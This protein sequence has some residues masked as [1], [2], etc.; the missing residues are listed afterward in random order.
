ML[1]FVSF[2]K[3]PFVLVCR[4]LHSSTRVE[5]TSNTNYLQNNVSAF[6]EHLSTYMH[7]EKKKTE[8]NNIKAGV[9]TGG[10]NKSRDIV[11]R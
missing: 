9:H 7:R 5:A 4:Y 11:L 3:L 6:A 8:K 10:I 1:A 2:S